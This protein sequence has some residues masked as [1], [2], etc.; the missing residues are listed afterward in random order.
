MIIFLNDDRAYLYWVTHHRKG[1]VMDGRRRPKLGH[2]LL[3][4]ATCG[5]VKSGSSRRMH[6]TTGAKL[7]ACSLNRIELETWADEESGHRSAYCSACAPE[8]EQSTNG[9]EPI[10]LSKLGAD[11]LD[12]VLD[13]ALI[14]M[15]Q[16]HPPY[17]LTVTDIAACFGKTPGQISSVLHNL[18]DDGFVTV[19]GTI[20]N[21]S[22]IPS[23]RIVLPTPAAL[24]TL[25][26]FRDE[27]DAAI[28]VEL[29]KLHEE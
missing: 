28:Q 27:S 25:E 2:L 29:E 8:S 7:K 21:A 19:P 9:H 3:H 17:R 16:E 18:I 6:Y 10:H 20:A 13:A 23:K 1:Y 5:E 11:V 15:E 22:P 4:R 12:Y 26:A 24:R 14:H